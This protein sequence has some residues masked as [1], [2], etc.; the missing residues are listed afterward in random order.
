MRA[1]L[2]RCRQCGSALNILRA[3][4]KGNKWICT[5]SRYN[6]FGIAHYTWHCIKY[7]TPCDIVLEQIRA[8]ARKDF[9]DEQEVAAQLRENCQADEQATLKNVSC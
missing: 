1:G 7:D 4:Q 5:C 8:C 6:N 2:V 3:N 9:A